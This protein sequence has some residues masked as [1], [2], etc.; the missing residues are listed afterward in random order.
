MYNIGMTDIDKFY[1][2]A[3]RLVTRASAPGAPDQGKLADE[4]V[5]LFSIWTRDYG[6]L[7]T[8]IADYWLGTYAQTLSGPGKG[9]AAVEWLGAA[10]SLISGSFTPE[11][12]F[13]DDDWDEIR[14][15]ISAEAD[16]MDLDL[17]TS[18]MT[19]IVERGKA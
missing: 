12:D 5:R 17:L 1:S 9:Q 13:P 10:L 16:T 2:D 15:I 6:E 19:I 7:G 3:D 8:A 11:M 14:E 18:I 4:L